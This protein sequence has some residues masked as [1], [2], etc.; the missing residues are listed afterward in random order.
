MRRIVDILIRGVEFV[1]SNPQILYTLFLVIII[2]FAFFFTSEQFLKVAQENQDKLE[3]SKIAVLQ[4]TFTIFAREHLNDSEYLDTRIK[5]IASKNETIHSFRVVGLVAGNDLPVIAS[6]DDREVGQMITLDDASALLFGSV[7]G[8][9][10]EVFT[11]Q[12]SVDGARYWRGIGAIKEE[13]TG[14]VVGYTV[15]DL[16]MAQAD[17]VAKKSIINA[18][19]VLFVVVLLILLLLVRQARILD[20]ATLYKRLQELDKVKD[21]F[22]S[23]AAHELRTPLLVIRGYAQLLNGIPNLSDKDRESVERIDI[24]AKDLAMLVND[25]LDVAR[26]EQGKLSLTP[27][28]IEFQI[29]LDSLIDSFRPLAEEKKLALRL[30]FP[31]NFPIIVA[32]D[33]RLRQV[34][35]NIVGNAVKYTNQGG[36]AVSVRLSEEG[37]VIVRV[38]DT[39]IGISSEE[40]KQLFQ[41]F[42]RVKNKE[43]QDIRGTGLGLWITQQILAAMNGGVS[44]ESIKGKG[45]DFIIT[46]PVNQK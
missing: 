2:P 16:S 43:T 38:S 17:L 9:P 33:T 26:I 12:L 6:M 21:D 31:A 40:Q 4:D 30:D 18:Y 46:F 44:V 45:T 23:M 3:R 27:T 25:I 36:V 13:V 34:L 10:D 5:D 20:Y 7:L 29:F 15:V 39:G 32:D 11:T 28:N 37:N 19:L 22:M 8:S 35:T 1:R 14:N 41:K 42:Y 24:S